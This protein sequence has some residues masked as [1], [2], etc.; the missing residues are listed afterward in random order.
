[1]FAYRFIPALLCT[2]FVSGLIAGCG[3]V[4]LAGTT[5]FKNQEPVTAVN[6]RKHVAKTPAENPFFKELY[7]F[8]G[9]YHRRLTR[10]MELRATGRAKN[11]NSMDEVP[12]STWFTNRIG[13]RDMTPSE[14][15]RGPN[16]GQSPE[17]AKPWTIVSSKVGGKS[18]G[19]IMEDAK[20]E[21]YLLK[22]DFK[23]FGEIETGV[24]VIMA[25]L[26]HAVGYNVP[27][28]YVVYFKRDDLIIAKDAAVKDVFG[29]KTPLT[30]EVFDRELKKINIGEDGTIRGLASKFL[31]GKPLGG[32][33]RDWRREDDP[34]D[35][36]DHHERRDVR[37]QYAIFAWLDHADIK[38][39]NTLDVFVED[40]ANPKVKY[41]KHYLLDFGNALGT[42]ATVNSFKY[43]GFAHS[44]DFTQMAASLF[45]LG[46]WRRAWET[47]TQPSI[48]GV[49]FIDSQSL[50]PGN[51]R[52]YTPSY[53]A[54]EDTDRFDN[55]W[56][57]KIIANF[58]RPHI[59]AAVKEARYSDPQAERYMTQVLVER[60]RRVSRYWFERVNPLDGFTVEKKGNAYEVCFDDLLIKHHL[61]YAVGRTSYAVT[62]FDYKGGATG[63]SAKAKATSSGRACVDGVSPSSSSQGYTILRLE[64][65]RSINVKLRPDERPLP[66]TL[67]HLAVDPTKGELRII[68]L[69]R[70]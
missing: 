69:R 58:R 18:V 40:P 70:L 49:G 45:S 66:P 65:D 27:E 5:R 32:R 28:D 17:M 29:N 16:K 41:V 68:G 51:W 64:T 53:F 67:L 56:G 37:G 9:H 10:K 63:F 34:N 19:F 61:D 60:Q 25:R 42:Q 47:R 21:R 24:D 26:L 3:A 13:V 20:G 7:H 4:P 52:P 33:T 38:E 14:V 6:D 11:V 46:I 48:K 55:F 43:I 15:A 59:E 31:P 1:M 30:N 12:N 23:G 39:D 57:A 62:G 36:I 54:F 2:V 50:D 8:D 44:I 22:F 35:T